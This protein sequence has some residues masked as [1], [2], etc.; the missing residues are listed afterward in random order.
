MMGMSM[1]STKAAVVVARLG[2]AGLTGAVPVAASTVHAATPPKSVV[3][4]PA[5][6][7]SAISEEKS[8]AVAQ[9]GKSL[10]AEQFSFRARTLRVYPGQNGQPLHIMHSMKVTVRRPDRLMVDVTGDDGSIKLDYDGKSV[11]VWGGEVNKYSTIPAP[12]TIQRTLDMVMERLNVDF[13]LADFLSGAPDKSV[14]LGVTSGKVVN[15]VT[16]DGVECLHLL[17]TEPPGVEVE[18]WLEKNDRSLPRR[19][20]ITYRTMSGQPNVVAEM[21]DWDFSIHPT[22]ADFVFQP[23]KDAVQVEM[24]PAAILAKPKGAKP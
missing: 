5:V 10:L 17:F 13:P 22:D 24:K 3:Q 7:K 23:P 20:I 8:A 1:K 21:S 11:T 15:T 18:L 16:I 9:M 6:P 14:L 19:L 12:G 4:K 2:I